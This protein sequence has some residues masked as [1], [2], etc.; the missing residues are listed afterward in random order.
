[1]K[2]LPKVPTWHVAAIERD[3]NSRPTGRK[4]ST[5]LMRHHASLCGVLRLHTFNWRVDGCI[6]LLKDKVVCRLLAHLKAVHLI[7]CNVLRITIVYYKL[8]SITYPKR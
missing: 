7:R 8:D 2:D 3:S 4:A 6:N 5:L 1:M